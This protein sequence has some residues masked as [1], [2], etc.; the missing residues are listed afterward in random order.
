MK[1]YIYVLLTLVFFTIGAVVF[2]SCGAVTETPNPCPPGGC[3]PTSEMQ[4]VY[5]NDVYGVT[6][7]FP[8]G[9]TFEESADKSSVTFE[10]PESEVTTALITFTRLDPKPM[11]LFEYLSETY[12]DETFSN[13]STMT[14]V[15]YSFDNP[16]TGEHGGDLKE[17]FFLNG[18]VLVH[19][20]AEIF[21]SGKIGLGVLLNGIAFK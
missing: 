8:D 10:S 21:L 3:A 19:V 6:I 12:P 7:S 14:L 5:E 15:G 18:D 17:Y 16:K 4:T 11:S 20:E 9:W 1:I 13:Y 2:S